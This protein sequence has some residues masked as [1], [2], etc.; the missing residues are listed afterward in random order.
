MLLK[1]NIF[2][3]A[4]FQTLD[5]YVLHVKAKI[6]DYTD[7]SSRFFVKKVLEV[8]R[9]KFRRLLDFVR[10]VL[11][12]NFDVECRYGQSLINT[13]INHVQQEYDLGDV[14]PLTRMIMIASVEGKAESA[15]EAFFKDHVKD[16]GLYLKAIVNY[17]KV[18]IAI[19]SENQDL[20]ES[21]ANTYGHQIL[22]TDDLLNP[23]TLLIDTVFNMKQLLAFE[24]H[25]L[26][27]VYA[28]SLHAR[29]N[30]EEYLNDCI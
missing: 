3:A 22:A 4:V 16:Q 14:V 5:R 20:V 2:L 27:M 8:E 26:R 19:M 13:C 6:E 18:V 25:H 21:N 15:F 9:V 24:G 12:H 30:E 1:E 11:N 23:G 10:L 7:T 17:I 28:K 29:E